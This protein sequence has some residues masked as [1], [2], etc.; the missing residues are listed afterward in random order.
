MQI[1]LYCEGYPGGRG[2][3]G[4]FPGGMGG[5]GGMGRGG[6]GGGGGPA[7][8]D[9]ASLFNDPELMAAFQACDLFFAVL[10]LMFERN[11]V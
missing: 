4:G 11:L 9:F 6:G 3:P 8:M 10:F 5:M 2:F 1:V 7:G